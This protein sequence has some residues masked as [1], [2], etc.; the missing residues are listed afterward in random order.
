MSGGWLQ[1]GHRFRAFTSPNLLSFKVFLNKVKSDH[2]KWRL[3]A[4]RFGLG[5]VNTGWYEP[6][7]MKGY[8]WLEETLCKETNYSK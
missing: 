7:W 8:P 4:T 3:S 1:R 6:N 5:S 2:P